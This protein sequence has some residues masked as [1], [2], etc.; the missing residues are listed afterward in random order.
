MFTLG[1]NPGGETCIFVLP[2]LTGSI[3]PRER[4]TVV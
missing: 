4:V 2:A 3:A 1:S